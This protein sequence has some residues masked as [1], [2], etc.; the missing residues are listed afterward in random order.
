MDNA[1]AH[2]EELSQHL[3]DAIHKL[4]HTGASHEAISSVL[5]LKLEVVQQLLDKNPSQVAKLTKT[6]REE[7]QRNHVQYSRL[8]TSPMM[9]P[10]VNYVEQSQLKPYPSM[11]S[12]SVMT[13]PSKRAKISEVCM[14]SRIYCPKT[15]KHLN[16][17][18]SLSSSTATGTTLTSC[19]GL[20]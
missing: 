16:F 3:V 12:E 15:P 14:G 2:G 8:K 9:A 5:G 1:T 17:T 11:S 6:I 7:S 19:T 18:P 4:A 13:N 20:V 10:D